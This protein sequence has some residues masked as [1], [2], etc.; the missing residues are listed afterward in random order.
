MRTCL[1]VSCATLLWAAAAISAEVC[2][3]QPATPLPQGVKAVWDLSKAYRDTTATRQRICING[4]WRWQPAQDDSERVPT[5]NWGYFKVP[6]PWPRAA[7]GPQ[8]LYPHPSWKSKDFSK[9]DAAWYQREIDIP[10]DW[11]GRNIAVAAECLNSSAAVFV[12]GKKAGTMYFPGGQVDITAA[13]R[14]GAKHLL[15]LR[16]AAL[17]LS[18]LVMVYGQT[19]E[20]KLAKAD[21]ARRG[22]CGDVFLTSVPAG[23]RIDDL[24]VGTSIAK[25]EITFDAA[26]RGLKP[27]TS[28][29]LRAVVRDGDKEAGR[30]TSRPFQAAALKDGRF[31]FAAAW[32]P[33]KLWDLNTPGNTYTAELTLLQ[34]DK[35]LDVYQP[36]RFGFREFSISGRD[37][38]LNGSRIFCM[39]VPF[40]SANGGPYEASYEGARRTLEGL[41]KMG[42]NTVFTHYY[43]CQPGAHSALGEVLQAAD[44]VGILVSLSQ[45]HFSNYDWRSPDAIERNGYAHHA[46]FYV[47]TAQ[48]H[49]S[50]VFYSTSHNAT[51][52]AED[53]NPDQIGDAT[54]NRDTAGAQRNAECALKAE[55]IIRRLDATRVVYHHSSGNMS[56]MYTANMYL[57]FVPIRERSDWFEHWATQGV[58]PAMLVEYGPPL[59]PSFTMYRGWYKNTRHYLE[60]KVPWELCTAEWA[61]QFLGDAA[62]RLTDMEEENLRFEAQRQRAGEPE[63]GRARFPHEFNSQRFAPPNRVDVQ[64]LYIK[65]NWP[66]FRTWGLSGPSGWS[67]DRF[68]VV[69]PDFVAQDQ[70][71][72]VD[73]EHLQRP[74]YS[75]DLIP[76]RPQL[77]DWVPNSAGLAFLRYSQPL[78]AYLGGKPARF[79]TRDHNF[80]PGQ[81]VD[82][83]III[84]NNSRQTA[85]CDCTWSL[86]LPQVVGGRQKITV[87]TGEQGRIR[88]QV[89]L[90]ADLAPG[91]YPL[92]LSMT[93]LAGQPQ[94]DSFDIDVLPAAPVVSPEARLAL[95]DPKGETRKLLE[96]VGI[97]TTSI[98]AD[99]DPGEYDVLIVGKAALTLDGPAPNI[100][101]VR[102]GLKVVVFEQTS[103]VLEKRLGFR[104]QEYGLRNVFAR[105]PNHPVLAG[106]G[107]QNLHDWQGEATI[108]ASRLKY[109][110]W[111]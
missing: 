107:Q 62:Y 55:A 110:F 49:P 67:Y 37:F 105:V 23:G 88:L 111:R 72:A 66:A 85:E 16:T 47:R 98:K 31:S 26:L 52:Y 100:G 108:M 78:L 40:E 103:E 90:P 84:I 50:V 64:A 63:Y 87:K 56:Q 9:V 106:L 1:H 42:I 51:Q 99:A 70:R 36:V 102:N 21:V 92:T 15:S 75:V 25:W 76:G 95:F 2:R 80:L 71:P 65:E 10:G 104:V 68:F 97:G 17:P 34:A 94:T 60:A 48:N 8:R 81:S 54:G 86:A 109:E 33:E 77:S 6:G 4:L 11:A 44:D 27:G 29:A 32:K 82:K 20:G 18:S 3:G 24:R 91:T 79:T 58:M 46:E 61:A 39:V 35:P 73:W 96:A 38:Y 22:L 7:S 13:C 14:P 41:K 69:R 5:D 12:D 45:P 28:Y 93:S 53:L 74:G 89:P 43:N 57:N 83:Q 19:D 30:F 59:P 101:G